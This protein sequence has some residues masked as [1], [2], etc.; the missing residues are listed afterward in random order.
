M[1]EPLRFPS[2]QNILSLEAS[3]TTGTPIR[4]RDF[5]NIVLSLATE[6][7]SSLTLQVQ[8]TV[9]DSET[10]PDFS[11]SATFANRWD[12]IAVFDYIDPTTVIPGGT[13]ISTRGTDIVR[14]LLVNTDALC[15]IC[16]TITSYSAGAVSVDCIG[17][18]NQ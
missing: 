7:N 14:N 18:N 8:G 10:A 13:G 1:A 16:V 3:A 11:A 17:F 15:W 12:Y 4:V 2:S 6:G 5:Q 9:V